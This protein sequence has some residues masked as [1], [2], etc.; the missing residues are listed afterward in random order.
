[1]ESVPFLP[2]LL[3]AHIYITFCLLSCFY[4]KIK[5]FL[6]ERKLTVNEN[7]EFEIEPNEK[8]DF[9]HNI[10]KEVE[11]HSLLAETLPKLGFKDVTITHERGNVP[12]NGK[13][14]ICS[15]YDNIED[16]KDWYAF[17]VKKGTISGTSSLF[18]SILR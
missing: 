2:H 16:K 4:E 17:V 3:G 6:K 13:D 9:L 18:L 1:M 7:K 5:N 15:C 11:I 8:L 12:E 10:K 14:L